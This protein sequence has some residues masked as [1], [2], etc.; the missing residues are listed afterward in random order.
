MISF[1]LTRRRRQR[2]RLRSRPACLLVDRALLALDRVVLRALLGCDPLLVVAVF[3]FALV[4][5]LL[6]EIV[7]LLLFDVTALHGLIMRPNGDSAIALSMR[8]I[9]PDATALYGLMRPSSSSRGVK[10]STG[11]TWW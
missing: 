6:F 7:A 9:N 3:L 1:P 11:T 4:A 10:W 8:A 2:L 5:L